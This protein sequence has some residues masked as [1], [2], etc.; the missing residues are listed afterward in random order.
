MDIEM[1]IDMKMNNDNDTD[2]DNFNKHY[3]TTTTNELKVLRF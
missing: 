3:C 2:M 1:K